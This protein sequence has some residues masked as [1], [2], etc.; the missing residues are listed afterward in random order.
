MSIR[1]ASVPASHVYVRHLSEPDSGPDSE[2]VV[3]LPDPPPMRE[4]APAGAPWWPPAML[5]PHWVSTHEF[6]LMHVH[7]G[8]DAQTPAQLHE[9]LD[10]MEAKGTPL[11]YTV[12]DLWN[13]HHKDSALHESQLEVLITRASAV[14]TLSAQAAEEIKHRWGVDAKVIAHPHVVD[15]ELLNAYAESPRRSADEFRLGIHLKSLR[16]NMVGIPVLEA[17]TAAL[18]EIPRAVLQVDV[19]RDV[20]ESSGA[21]HVAELASWLKAQPADLVDLRVHDYFSDTELFD[22]LS[23]LHASLLPYRFGTHSGWL[24]AAHDVGTPVIAPDVGCYRSQGADFIYSWND[25]GLDVP[26]LRQAVLEAAAAPGAQAHTDLPAWRISQRREIAAA[27]DEIYRRVL[28][29]T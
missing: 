21:R 25:A 18:R 4:K 27:H 14:I 7:F 8:F 28:S 5:D 17:T 15:L 1:V 13:P 11:V 9:V 12:H 3:R 2:V 6:D 23:S 26:S 19:H 22:Y 10:A 16:A 24:E 29:G 20:F